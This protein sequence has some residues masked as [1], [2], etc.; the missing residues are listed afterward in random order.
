[1]SW[2]LI[3]LT[4]EASRWAMLMLGFAEF[5]FAAFFRGHESRPKGRSGVV[6]SKATGTRRL[7]RKPPPTTAR[8]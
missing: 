3:T 8:L 4:P 5:G 7:K 1:M 6:G 2:Q